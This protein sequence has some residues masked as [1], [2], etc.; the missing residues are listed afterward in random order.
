MRWHTEREKLEYVDSEKEKMLSHPL[1]DSQW[2]ALDLEYPEFRK[3]SRNLRL[4]VSA[5]GLNPF[6]GQ[7]STHST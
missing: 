2:T 4:G 7:S 3:D 6:N 1:D 5:D